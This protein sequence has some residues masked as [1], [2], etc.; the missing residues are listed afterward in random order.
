MTFSM[1]TPHAPYV[2]GSLVALHQITHLHLNDKSKTLGNAWDGSLEGD[3]TMALVTAYLART[4]RRR[5]GHATASTARTAFG[6]LAA[7]VR[8]I[9]QALFEAQELR[10]VM[11]QKYPFTDV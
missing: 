1:C 6:R 5:A 7:F 3:Q 8:A 4:A 11:T 9:Q 2:R 10:R